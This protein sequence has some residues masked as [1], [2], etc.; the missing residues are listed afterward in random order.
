MIWLACEVGSKKALSAG[1]V[2]ILAGALQ[3]DKHRIDLRQHIWIG[4]VQHPSLLTFVVIQQNS[5]V[6]HFLLIPVLFSPSRIDEFTLFGSLRRKVVRIKYQR[7][8]FGIE[9]S[10]EGGLCPPLGIGIVDVN[11]VK[12][13]SPDDVSYI[14]AAGQK[15]PL[16]VQ[17]VLLV[18]EFL[19]QVL[20]LIPE[21]DQGIGIV[22]LG[23]FHAAKFFHLGSEQRLRTVRL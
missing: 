19:R 20:H 13:P 6:P 21:R 9:G 2:P 23:G 11:N 22:D 17:T 10:C 5:Q 18:V 14:A 3:R 7:L 1:C 8:S 16:T 4:E 12:I 15:L